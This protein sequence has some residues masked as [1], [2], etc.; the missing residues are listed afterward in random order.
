MIAGSYEPP[1]SNDFSLSTDEMHGNLIGSCQQQFSLRQILT[2]SLRSIGFSC[3]LVSKGSL[4]KIYQAPCMLTD[5][6]SE[7]S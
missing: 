3:N 2:E 4:I 6:C 7:P 1:Q 5:F